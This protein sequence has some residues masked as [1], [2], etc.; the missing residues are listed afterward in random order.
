MKLTMARKFEKS[1]YEWC[2]E[3]NHEDWLELWDYELN[4]CSPKEVGYGSN[5]KYWF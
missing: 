4:E 2:I 1:F 3:N 5:K